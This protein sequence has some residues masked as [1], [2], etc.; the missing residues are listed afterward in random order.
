MPAAVTVKIPLAGITWNVL[1]A[2]L[3]DAGTVLETRVPGTGRDGG[4]NCATVKPFD[5]WKLTRR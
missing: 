1:D 4:P 3:T 5:S 2:A